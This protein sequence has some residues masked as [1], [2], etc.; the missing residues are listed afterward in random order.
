M[1]TGDENIIDINFIVLWVIK[2]AESYLF[3][4]RNP[5]GTVKSAA[6]SAMREVIGHSEIASALTGGRPKI[7]TETQQLLQ[8][9]LDSYHAGIE[10]TNV[11]LQKVDPPNQVIDAF[12]DVQSAKIDQ[13]R[14]INEAESYRNNIVPVAHGDGARIVQEAEAYRQQVVLNA[15]GDAARFLSV[16]DSYKVAADIT[17]RRLYIET[18]QDILAAHQQD[19]PRQVGGDLGRRALPAAAAAARAAGGAGASAERASAPSAGAAAARERAM[20]TRM[21]AAISAAVVVLL[22]VAY[23]CLFTVNQI[24]QALVLQFGKPI[25]VVEAPGLHVKLPWQEVVD[26]DRRILDFEPPAEEVIASDQKRLVV[27]TYA[28]FRITDPLQFY[29]S[30]GTELVVR[31]R[32]SAIMTGALRRVI[33]GIELQPV[34]SERRAA[35]MHQ[36]RDEVNTQSKG[37]GIDVIDVRV[38]RADLPEENSQAIFDRMKSERQRE[39]AGYRAEGARQAQQ[40]RADA[41]RQRIEI[42]ANSQKQSQILRGQGDGDAIKITADAYGKDAAFFTFYRSLQ[43]Y[44]EG[45]SGQGTTLVL[46]PDSSFFKILENGPQLGGEPQPTARAQAR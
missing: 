8:E 40:I 24:E 43:A 3:N 38:K 27:D 2:D 6:E 35:I 15:Q 1:L 13:Q 29:Q 41:D 26:Y 44:R 37:F 18:M 20:S 9:I 11:Q 31:Q 10:I 30:V 46:S 5:D 28:R 23:S 34:I 12:R 17:A 16:Y 32:L 22:V 25:R 42:I 4:I 14:L 45:L 33:G 19:H 36:I 39:A 7:E 21:L